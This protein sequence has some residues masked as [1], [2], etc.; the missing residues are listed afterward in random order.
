MATSVNNSAPGIIILTLILQ[1]IAKKIISSIFI[2]YSILQIILLI[3]L[4]TNVQLP[5]SV[6]FIATTI[7]GIIN[8]SSFDMK[9]ILSSIKLPAI[10][11]NSLLAKLS[12]ISL[13]IL[14]VLVLAVMIL[15]LRKL[16]LSEK[17]KKFVKT[18]SN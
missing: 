4:H 11:E 7:D 3:S 10:E 2:F 15:I 8:L 17:L 9:S 1:I 13:A 5:A 12:G 18:F 16:K 14:V 6:T